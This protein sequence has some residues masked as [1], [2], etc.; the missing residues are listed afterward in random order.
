MRR[1]ENCGALIERLAAVKPLPP[2]L[3][4]WPFDTWTG[5]ARPPVAPRAAA[6]RPPARGSGRRVL[7]RQPPDRRRGRV[8]ELHVPTFRARR[9]TTST[10]AFRARTI[11]NRTKAAA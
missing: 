2:A 7:G 4:P 6:A 3:G 8:Q 9:W 10:A 1:I 5:G 11:S